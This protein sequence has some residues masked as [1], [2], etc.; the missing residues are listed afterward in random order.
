MNNNLPKWAL[1]SAGRD[2]RD[3]VARHHAAGRALIDWPENYI[4]RQWASS[5]GW[6]ASRFFLRSKFLK[7]LLESDQSF[8]FGIT[9]SGVK[10]LIP[11]ERHSLSQKELKNLDNLYDSRDENGYPDG[12]NFLVEELREIRRAV[13]AGIEVEVDGK[14]LKDFNSFYSW[15]HGRYH[16]LEDGADKWI[17]DDS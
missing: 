12:L 13:E 1:R 15:A 2:D 9:G 4:L 7:K 3:R 10:I 11:V 5:R 16:M 8:A 6:P 14:T 17:G